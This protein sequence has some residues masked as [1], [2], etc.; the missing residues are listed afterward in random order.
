MLADRKEEA[1]NE[2]RDSATKEGDARL[3]RNLQNADLE[4]DYTYSPDWWCEAFASKEIFPWLWD[5][6][7]CLIEEKQRAGCWNWELLIRQL[8]QMKIHEPNDTSLKLPL[9]LR[10]RRRIWRLLEEAKVNDIAEPQEKRIAAEAEE[11]RR[12]RP[13]V[14]KGPWSPPGGWNLQNLPPGFLPLAPMHPNHA[15][16]SNH[17]GTHTT[18]TPEP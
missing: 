7:T 10:N 12:S 14:S 8:S 6:D 18:H 15:D 5:V 1:Q 17:A 4:C 2:T 9:A 11:A 3:Y 16:I 13:P